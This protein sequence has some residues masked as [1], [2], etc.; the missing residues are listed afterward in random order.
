MT[1]NIL[2]ELPPY[3]LAAASALP[4]HD[5]PVVL[6]TRHSIRERTNGLGLAGYALPLTKQGRELAYAWGEQLTEQSGRAL[7]H[8][9]SSPI[10][11]CL[12]TAE[13]M[14]QGA[15]NTFP[16]NTHQIEVLSQPLLV[17]P[18][19]F[20]TDIQQAA[21][22][23]KRKG[24]IGFINSFV[25][26]DL[27]GVKHPVQGILDILQLLYQLQAQPSAVGQLNLAVSHDTILA[28]FIAV[29]SGHFKVEK[30]DW[31]KMMEG[32]FV[33]FEQ[34]EQF[35]QSQLHWLWRGQKQHLKIRQLLDA[36]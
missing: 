23:F 25:Q 17:E 33:W 11:R 22:F 10:Q 30:T 28:A 16:N 9:F 32:V 26:N 18:G 2:Q 3:M 36:M 29:I 12:D 35:E 21:P 5:A 19:G 34:A 15:D 1:A 20:V 24:A 4:E 31:P 8:C 7:S 14:I 6:F 13:L 27:P